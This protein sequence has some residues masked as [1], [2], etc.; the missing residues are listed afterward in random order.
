MA[1]A[2]EPDPG[3]REKSMGELFK[4]LSA[5]LSTLVRQEMQLARAEMT[6]K[7]KQAGLGAGMFGGAGI[8]ALL[9]AGTLSACLIAALS[10]AMKV[11]L[12]ALII[13]ALYVA[14]AAVLALVAKQRVR[15]VTP[16]TP[17]QTVETVEEDVQW[18]KTQLPS[19]SR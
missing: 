3:L 11:W 14:A 4:E 16:P 6:E 1:Q 2:N 9:A 10:L 18:A 12:A 8:V 15:Q 13:T 5:D 17:E 19:G 7:G